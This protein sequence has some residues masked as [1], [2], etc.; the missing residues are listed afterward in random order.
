MKENLTDLNDMAGANDTDLV[1]LRG[2]LDNPAVTQLIK[3][4]IS[5]SLELG[6][7]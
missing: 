5:I 4:G 6:E 3:V 2:L 1:F 7:F